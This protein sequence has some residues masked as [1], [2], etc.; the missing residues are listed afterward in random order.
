MTTENKTDA[1]EAL[2][3]RNSSGRWVNIWRHGITKK[4]IRGTR[5][6]KDEETARKVAL[7]FAWEWEGVDWLGEYLGVIRIDE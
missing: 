6:F 5:V 2:D 1:A 3:V 4:I 7:N